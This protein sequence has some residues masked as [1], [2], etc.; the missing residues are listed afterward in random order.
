[1]L[2]SIWDRILK[3]LSTYRGYTYIPPFILMAITFYHEVENDFVIWP[4]GIIIILMG[5]SIR[6]WATKHIGRRM[7][8]IKKKGKKLV[9]TGPYAMVRNPLYIGNIT[10]AAGL[11]IL[12][13]L[14]WM[15]P[16]VILYL[17]VIYH[18]V[19]LF[20]EKK[21]L[22]RWP[23]EYQMYLNK[24]PRWIPRFKDLETNKSEGFRWRNALRSELPSIYVILFA[25]LIFVLKEFFSH[26]I[27]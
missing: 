15:V 8:W 14:I 13:K 7:P 23:S 1:M 2:S 26:R 9:N 6:V 17:F 16:L 20:E 25:I 10:I 18:L 19:A 4:L 22:A 21:L 27:N 5:I 3:G 24:V 11:S 12:S